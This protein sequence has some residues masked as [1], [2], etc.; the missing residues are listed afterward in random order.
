V[1][2]NSSG[3]Q[4]ARSG[5]STVSE[6]VEAPATVQAAATT[7]SPRPATGTVETVYVRDGQRVAAGT[8][9]FHISSPQAEAQADPGPLGAGPGRLGRRRT[10]RRC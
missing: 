1:H 8:L 4:V 7:T 3:I 6:V 5:R 9:L 10:A 2:G